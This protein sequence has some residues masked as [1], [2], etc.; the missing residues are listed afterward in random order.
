[1]ARWYDGHKKLGRNIDQLQYLDGHFRDYLL[2][3]VLKLIRR[4]EP[5]LLD[6]FVAEFPFE[7]HRRRWYDRDP[8]LWLIINGLQYAGLGLQDAVADFLE[9]ET[10]RHQ[11]E[12]KSD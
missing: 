10:K 11:A 5:R 6:T 3:G 8:Y 7:F 1:M 12:T 9:E 4:D 2:A